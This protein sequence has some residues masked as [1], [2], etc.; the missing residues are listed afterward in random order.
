MW[1]E[2]RKWYKDH[3]FKL[4]ANDLE[5]IMLEWH[6]KEQKLLE[7]LSRHGTERAFMAPYWI[8]R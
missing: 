8:W 1:S 3:G 2:I 4:A 6:G 7:I 5:A